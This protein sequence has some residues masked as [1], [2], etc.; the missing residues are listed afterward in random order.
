MKK[1]NPPFDDKSFPV[2]HNV[3]VA[4]SQDDPTAKSDSE[5]DNRRNRKTPSQKKEDS[6]DEGLKE[7]FPASDP[8]SIIPAAPS[9]PVH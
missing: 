4:H 5:L 1:S 9:R 3:P 6:L 7:T 2:D 8:V